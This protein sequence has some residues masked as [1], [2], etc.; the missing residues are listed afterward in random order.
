MGIQIRVGNERLG[1][2]NEEQLTELILTEPIAVKREDGIV[3]ASTLEQLS[4]EFKISQLE[5]KISQH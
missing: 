4:P 3:I 2:L 1:Q 5:F